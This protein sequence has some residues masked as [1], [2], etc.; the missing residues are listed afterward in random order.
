MDSTAVKE[1]LSLA[2]IAVAAVIAARVSRGG[3]VDKAL[4]RLKSK[5]GEPEHHSSARK[6][7]AEAA[8]LEGSILE[9]IDLTRWFEQ[10]MWQAGVYIRV[11]EMLLVMVMLFGI[12]EVVADTL[13]DSWPLALAC[14]LGAAILPVPYIRLLRRRRLRKFAAQLPLR[15][16]PDQILAGGWSFAPTRPPGRRQGTR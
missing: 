13:F 7:Q 16:R 5:P 11:S 1:F 9:K 2:L 15:A 3:R 10:N 14:G 8:S 12:A 4:E 6:R